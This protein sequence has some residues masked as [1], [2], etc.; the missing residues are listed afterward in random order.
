MIGFA[1]CETDSRSGHSVS[2]Q[3]PTAE[4]WDLVIES[5]SLRLKAHHTNVSSRGE[6]EA[7]RTSVKAST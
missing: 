3:L 7:I 5:S 4:I 2:L 6:K 1:T